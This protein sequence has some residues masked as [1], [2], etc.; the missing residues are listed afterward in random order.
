MALVYAFQGS[1]VVLISRVC[2][3]TVGFNPIVTQGSWDYRLITLCKDLSKVS[4]PIFILVSE[5]N[6]EKFEWLGWQAR[7][8]IEPGSSSL[9]ILSKIP[10]SH[11]SSQ[12]YYTAFKLYLFD[13][14]LLQWLLISHIYLYK[15]LFQ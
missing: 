4:K 3:L 14:Y 10:L 9:P 6:I 8:G 2:W 5:K 7:P 12:V 13:F 1:N 11:F 15:R